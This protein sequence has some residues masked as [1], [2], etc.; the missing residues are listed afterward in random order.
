[1]N[2][3]NNAQISNKQIGI[4]MVANVVSYSANLI[5]SFVLTPFLIN[6]LG[7]EIYSFYPIANTVV[8]YMSVITNALNSMASRFVTVSLVE[9]KKEE[10]NKYFS[11]VLMSNICI[12]AIVSIP[13]LIMVIFLDKFMNVPINSIAA[14]KMLFALV[15]SSALLN[16]ISSIYG[17]ATFAKNRIDLRSVRELVTAALRL[18]LF[19]VLYKFLPP[20][21]VYVGVVTL[22]VAIVNMLFQRMYTKKLLPEIKISRKYFSIQHIKELMASSSWNAINTLGNTLLAGMSMILANL[23]YGADASGSYSIVQTVPQ[24]INGV[25]V[26]L[27]GVFYPVITYKYAQ[28]DRKG[29]IEQI[30]NAQCLVG[31]FGCS[32]IAV[33]SALATEFFDLWT[34]GQNSEYLALLSFITIIPHFIISCVW[35][36]TNLNVVMNKVKIPALVTLLCGIL[37]VILAC[38]VNRFFAGGILSFAVI[39]SLIQIIWVGVFIPIYASKNLNIKVRVFYIPILKTIIPSA[40]LMLCIMQIKQIFSL[41]T[42]LELFLFGGT[43]GIIVLIVVGCSAMSV[44]SAALLMLCIMQI[45]QIFSLSTWLELFLFG[46]TTGIIVLIVVGCSAMSVRSAQQYV[47]LI[48]TRLKSKL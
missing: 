16:V 30:S 32:V 37:N 7:K 5:I 43:T 12:S 15:F 13:M 28:H 2:T 19:F 14:I 39:S 11:S 48:L 22:V 10:A 31:T 47:V 29:L 1:M 26:M 27:I 21:I 40:L 35:S 8:G 41:S 3:T 6:T 42:W 36:L 44:R 9:N 34:P 23:F 38:V 20:S 33:F 4:N 45:K 25:I 46:G 24:F 17:I 18:I